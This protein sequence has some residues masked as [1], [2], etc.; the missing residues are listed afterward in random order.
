MKTELDDAIAAYVAYVR[1]QLRIRD[2]AEDVIE[3]IAENERD[4]LRRNFDFVM[5]L[6]DVNGVA[7]RR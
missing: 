3:T 6:A 2:V 4:A 1:Q 7:E 5:M